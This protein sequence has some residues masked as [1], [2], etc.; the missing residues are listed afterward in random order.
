MIN[1]AILD[2]VFPDELKYADI[3]PLHKGEN[4][5]DKKNYRPI[6]MLPVISKVFERVM[7]KQIASFIDGKLFSY[8]CGY[9]KGY[10][11]QY[12]LMSLIEKG[13]N[14]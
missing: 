2:G 11:T 10:N 8:M 3:V 6:S 1:E 9:R 14:H 7:H 5:T 13:K 12:A 4:A